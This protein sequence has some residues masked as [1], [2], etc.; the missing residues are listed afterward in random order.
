MQ[1]EEKI[2]LIIQIAWESYINKVASGLFDPRNEKMMQLQLAQTLQTLMPIFEYRQDESIKVV[3]EMPVNINRIPDKRII[4]IVLLHT[5]NEVKQYFPIEIKCFRELTGDGSGKKRGAQNL[6]MFDYWCDIENVEQ[7]SKLENFGFGTQLTMTD[8][9]YYVRGRHQGTQVMTYSTNCNREIVS[10]LLECPI[11]SRCGRIELEG[12]YDMSNW[13][14][15]N[16]F[17]FILQESN[18]V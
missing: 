9:L 3:L 8:D 12:N 13:K 1:T 18:L 10:G 11:V 17:N 6:G 7:Y 15:I 4:D 14:L 16:N 2:R 5:E